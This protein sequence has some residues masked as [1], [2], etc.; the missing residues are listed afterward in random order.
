MAES[1]RGLPFRYQK[2]VVG[3]NI[4]QWALFGMPDERAF[5]AFMDDAGAW[6]RA[7]YS[8]GQRNAV[9]IDPSGMDDVPANLRKRAGEW[10]KGHQ[11]LFRETIIAA[12]YITPSALMR[13]VITAIFW[14]S[15][16]VVPVQT[17]ATQTEAL[18]WL[19][20]RVLEDAA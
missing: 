4:V 10:R 3:P 11:D 13:G 20:R 16:P 2:K 12:A 9:I 6:V 15:T 8:T 19:E 5:V 14:V 1:N 17:F 7:L 18:A